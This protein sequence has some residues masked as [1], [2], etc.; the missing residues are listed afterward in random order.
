M[1]NAYDKED[2][3]WLN[4]VKRTEKPCEWFVLG[5]MSADFIRIL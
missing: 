1:I 4:M 3:Q 2:L 5:D